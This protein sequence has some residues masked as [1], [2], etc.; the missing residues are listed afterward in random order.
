MTVALGWLQGGGSSCP[1]SA[2]P[3][4]P[5]PRAALPPLC[6]APC[7]FFQPRAAVPRGVPALGTHWVLTSE[8]AGNP[9]ANHFVLMHE[10]IEQSCTG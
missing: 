6:H 4:Q 2:H 1:S 7:S 9:C 8:P 3:H 5:R 10:M